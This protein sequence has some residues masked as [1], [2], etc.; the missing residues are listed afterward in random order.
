[1]VDPAIDFA[2]RD[3]QRAREQAQRVPHEGI[4]NLQSA[5][6]NQDTAGK[7]LE[8]I[9]KPEKKGWREKVKNI[10]KRDMGGRKSKD[11][12]EKDQARL[13]SETVE[14]ASLTENPVGWIAEVVDDVPAMT[15]QKDGPRDESL[16]VPHIRL[17]KSRELKEKDRLLREVQARQAAVPSSEQPLLQQDRDA[18]RQRQESVEAAAREMELARRKERVK[19]E[20]GKLEESLKETEKHF[21]DTVKAKQQEMEER[22]RQKEHDHWPPRI[23][24]APPRC[25]TEASSSSDTRPSA[26]SGPVIAESP[27][28]PSR[29][30]LTPPPQGGSPVDSPYSPSRRLLGTGPSSSSPFPPA[31]PLIS[32]GSSSSSSPTRVL[33]SLHLGDDVVTREQRM[34]RRDQAREQRE[35]QVKER[36]QV[37]DDQRKVQQKEQLEAAVAKQIKL[38][39]AATRKER[40]RPQ[41]DNEHPLPPPFQEGVFEPED[42]FYN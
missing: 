11:K 32:G 33:E 2:E 20:V 25:S 28:M 4:A 37:E 6:L 16:R 21:E 42:A 12:K 1:M 27:I 39:A 13:K 38:G 9:E 41:D 14:P 5:R 15:L 30:P 19:S 3:R 24:A 23:W 18:E 29:R 10:F 22:F 26:T 8:A 31:R 34:E 17:S 40:A 36:R 7:P 35:E